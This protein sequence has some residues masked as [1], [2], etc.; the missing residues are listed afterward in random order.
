M[1]RHRVNLPD[2]L[3]W[4][5]IIGHAEAKQQLKG[6][7]SALL[8]PDALH[9]V[10]AS[11]PRGLILHGE[12]G[13]G[14]TMSAR[15]FAV[16]LSRAAK[17]VG[18]PPVPFYEVMA[19]ELTPDCMSRLGRWSAAQAHT[20]VIYIDEIELWALNRT[21]YQHNPDTRAQLFAALSAIDGMSDTSQALWLASV[22]RPPNDLDPALRRPGR[23]GYAI[24]M[25]SPSRDDIE[26]LLRHHLERR[27]FIGP[28]PMDEATALMEGDTQA[29][30]VQALDDGAMLSLGAGESAMTWPYLRAAMLRRGRIYTPTSMDD[31]LRWRVC[32]HEAA[33]AIIGSH[34]WDPSGCISVTIRDQEY[35]GRTQWRHQMESDNAHSSQH[36]LDR[37]VV[38]LA[39]ITAEGELL[40]SESMGAGSDVDSA[41]G[42]IMGWIRWGVSPEFGRAGMDQLN[43]EDRGPAVLDEYNAI[44]R[45]K[46]AECQRHATRLVHEHRTEVVR[47]AQLLF[48]AED[49]HL[50]GDPLQAALRAA[51]STASA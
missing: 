22:N 36:P 42:S 34:I 48:D 6:M 25:G 2:T 16:E 8:N 41:T 5:S 28:I 35:G 47:M 15:V 40:G 46:V 51:L 24:G 23:L 7:V 9:A 17:E 45:M 21:D 11:L 30:V 29:A 3:T 1:E 44:I 12:P 33:H 39:G 18:R 32:I 20:A 26:A 13:T 43:R 31:D 49:G 37:A 38:A 14:K 19:S 4:D 27:S 50:A 10:G